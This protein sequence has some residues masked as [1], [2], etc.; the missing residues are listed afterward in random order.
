MPVRPAARVQQM[1][2]TNHLRV[3]IGKNSERITCLPARIAR[4]LWQVH[5]DRHRSNARRLEF[6]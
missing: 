4:D 2:T 5:A 1:V 6:S 3:R